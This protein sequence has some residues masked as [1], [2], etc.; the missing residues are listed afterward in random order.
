MKTTKYT[1]TSA[2]HAVARI[3]YQTNEIMPVYPITPATP[4]AEIAEE[5]YADKTQNCF[6]NVPEVISMQSEGGVA[7]T[8]HGALQTG[9]L[10]TTFTAS[11]GLLL[12]LPNMYKIAGELTPNVIHVAT[13]TIATH[14]LSVFGDHSDIM[15]IRQSGYAILGSSGVQEAQD[16]ALIAQAATLRSRVPFVHFFDGFR[17]SHEFNKIE[18]ADNKIIRAMI[19]SSDITAHRN[20]ALSPENPVIRGTAQGPESY[21]QGRE[22]ATKYYD[23][24]AGIVQET[25][26]SFNKLTGRAYQIFEYLGHPKA[27]NLIISMGSSTETIAA[28][29]AHLN[30][31]G[32]R[33]GMIR[34]RLYR[35][36]SAEHF[37]KAIPA[38]CKNI[39]VLDRTKES[40]STGEPLYLDVVQT[41]THAFQEGN[42]KTLPRIIGGRYG[43]SSK[44]F[45]PGMV[46]AIFDSLNSGEIKNGFTIG[47]DDDQH[48]SHISEKPIPNLHTGNDEIILLHGRKEGDLKGLQ[49]LT[50]KLG[51]NRYVQRYTECDYI[52]SF[53]VLT[54]HIRIAKEPV[55]APYLIEEAKFILCSELHYSQIKTLPGRMREGGVLIINEALKSEFK[56]GCSQEVLYEFNKKHVRLYSIGQKNASLNALFLAV[57]ELIDNDTVPTSLN[58]LVLTDP[59]QQQ[60]RKNNTPVTSPRTLMEILLAGEGNKAPVGMFPVDGT[61]ITDNTIASLTCNNGMIPDWDPE[62]C[63]QCGACTLACPQGSIRVKVFDQDSVKTPVG[64]KSAP[65]N[66]NYAMTGYD[67]MTIQV[68]PDQC[69]GCGNCENACPAK[70]LMMTARKGDQEEQMENWKHFEQLPEIDRTEIEATYL[71]LQQLQE[72]LFRYPKCDPGCGESPYIKLLTQM[73]GDRLLIANATGSSSIFGGIPSALPWRSNKEGK[74]PAWSNSLFEDN[75]E[76]GLGFRLSANSRERAAR[77]LLLQMLPFLDFDRV[78]DLLEA[79]QSTEEGIRQQRARVERLKIALKD[80]DH[81]QAGNLLSQADALIKKSIWIVGGDGW[82]Y[83]IGFGGLDHVLASGANVNILVLDNEVYDNTGGQASKATPAGAKARLAS[84]GKKQ[85]KKNLGAMAMQYDHVYVASVSMGADPDQMLKAFTEAEAYDGPSIIIAYC[86]SQAHGIDMSDPWPYHKEAVRSGRWELFISTPQESSA[87]RVKFSGRNELL[88]K[89][90]KNFY[91]SEKRFRHNERSVASYLNLSE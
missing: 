53:P 17:T 2:N 63:I 31:N 37:L 60:E 33:Y 24:C 82:A 44:E 55:K 18:V 90:E 83:D 52:K 5:W 30:Q 84:K 39:A 57:L 36:F 9:S 28:T 26:D 12:M 69:T 62:A 70:A 64:W 49:Y 66:K 85:A 68:N 87:K 73:F 46:A 35:P 13:R 48:Q 40:G 76:F 74:G 89:K 61:Y 8:L 50:Q 78:F 29:I 20:R 43:L 22:A 80:S 51:T 23:L 15:A 77:N 67:Q 19:D 7:G 34:V 47:I 54:S 59:G 16:M 88:E 25:M 11:Q 14:A 81:P 21:F 75:A 6:G 27:E 3:A 65:V 1:V 10:A 4:M 41:L 72:P 91:R 86:H 42:Q 71:P 45:T 58:K 32:S 38:T 56:K 79:D